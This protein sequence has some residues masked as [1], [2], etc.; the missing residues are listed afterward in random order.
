[1]AV[2]RRVHPR[3]PRCDPSQVPA[4]AVPLHPLR[5]R[6]SR[7]IA[8]APTPGKFTFNHRMGKYTDVVFCL[9]WYE[10]PDD[11][12]VWAREDAVMLGPAILVHP[13]LHQGADGVDVSLPK[14]VWYDFDTGEKH[15]GPKRWR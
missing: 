8:G 14:G 4:H 7:R 1:V 12:S 5:R 10:F 3:D 11:P 13:V 9:Q 2:R 15:V 6:E